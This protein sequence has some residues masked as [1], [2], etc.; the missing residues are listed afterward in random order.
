MKDF[1]QKKANEEAKKSFKNLREAFFKICL[2]ATEKALREK[3]GIKEIEHAFD[4]HLKDGIVAKWSRGVLADVLKLY[5]RNSYLKVVRNLPAAAAALSAGAGGLASEAIKFVGKK[6]APASKNF[7]FE[8]LRLNFSY[9]NY[10]HLINTGLALFA[11]VM[12]V[13]VGVPFMISSW[14][15]NVQKKAGKIGVMMAMDNID[16][17]R[18][19]APHQPEETSVAAD[20]TNLINKYLNKKE[21]EASVA[22]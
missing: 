15:T 3:G 22:A 21:T 12:A 11:P 20:G 6:L 9:K 10:R 14:L 5:V 13:V 2:D 18:V 4:A 17:A 7:I 1:W 16:D 8:K 19:F